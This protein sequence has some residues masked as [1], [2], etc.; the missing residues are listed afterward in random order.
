MYQ[1]MYQGRYR[2]ARQD[3]FGR[4]ELKAHLNLPDLESRP[5]ITMV[6]VSRKEVT[7][8]GRTTDLGYQVLKAVAEPPIS[9]IV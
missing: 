5:E 1:A 6:S 8:K 4:I 2:V 7:L 9:M 3:P